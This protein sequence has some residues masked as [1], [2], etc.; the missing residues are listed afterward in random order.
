MQRTIRTAYGPKDQEPYAFS[1]D[2]KTM[3]SFGPDCDVNRIMARYQV[4][5]AIE[6]FAKNQPQY[7][8]IP[9]M[10]F[11]EAMT[12]I[13]TANSLFAELPSEIRKQFDND[14][15]EFLEFVQDPAN[16]AEM[17]AMGLREAKPHEAAEIPLSRSE[18]PTEPPEPPAE[19][20]VEPT[21]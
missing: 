6:H 11:R 10:D 8:D 13:T 18:A 3:Q 7:G 15:S 17:I 14:P 16:E 4:T 21:P 19:P 20:P 5:G 2:T 1:G 12:A 9:A